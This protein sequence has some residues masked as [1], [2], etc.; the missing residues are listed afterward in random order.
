MNKRTANKVLAEVKAQFGTTEPVLYDADHEEMA[1]G[2]WSI[3]W[4]GGAE[5]WTWTFETAVPGVYVEAR[6]HWSLGLYD[7]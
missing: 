3:A 4:E 6:N 2:T 7:A 5:D 1:A